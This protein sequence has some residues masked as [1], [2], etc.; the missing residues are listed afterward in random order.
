MLGRVCRHLD[1]RSVCRLLKTCRHFFAMDAASRGWLLTQASP[2]PTPP[3]CTLLH[4]VAPFVP[5]RAVGLTT[6]SFAQLFQQLV[7]DTDEIY[8]GSN[9]SSCPSPI[10]HLLNAALDHLHLPPSVT[11]TT[12]LS[13]AAAASSQGGPSTPAGARAAPVEVAASASAAPASGHLRAPRPTNPSSSTQHSP[14]SPRSPLSPLSPLSPRSPRSPR[15]PHTSRVQLPVHLLRQQLQALPASPLGGRPPAH[16]IAAQHNRQARRRTVRCLRALLRLY[17]AGA[18]Q[19]LPS[20]VDEGK[21]PLHVAV[22][23]SWFGLQDWLAHLLLDLYPAGA[24]QPDADGHYPLMAAVF[25]SAPAAVCE[26]LLALHP[27]AATIPH[28]RS[29]LLPLHYAACVPALATVVLRLLE[30]VPASAAALTPEQATPLHL[31]VRA[32][33]PES[34]PR[35]LLELNPAAV[36][37]RRRDGAFPLH[38]ALQQDAEA[39][40][41]LELLRRHPAAAAQPIH[42]EGEALPL[43]LALAAGAPLEVVQALVSAYPD[44]AG[45]PARHGWLPLHHSLQAAGA[46]GAD[47]RVLAF[48]LDLYPIAATLPDADGR[49]PLHLAVQHQAPAT[50][51]RLVLSAHPPA[52]ARRDSHGLVPAEY[53]APGQ[54]TPL[55]LA[56]LQRAGGE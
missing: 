5:A 15:S 56:E 21:L 43:H 8:S 11:S 53:A 46:P 13:P 7:H 6:V 42:G 51:V 1:V 24:A 54:L 4:T 45:C 2:L 10:P 44:A 9:T 31:A 48:V 29:S 36:A 38:C 16:A 17:P 30:L 28:H 3:P 22:E 23:C 27:P 55:L 50:A 19:L 32:G 35:R 26:R 33:V 14:R 34:V 47:P 20:G 25:H 49:L 52:A 12:P 37:C 41:V 39:P 40:L 18:S